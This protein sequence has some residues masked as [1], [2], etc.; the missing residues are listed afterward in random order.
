SEYSTL[1]D[2]PLLVSNEVYYFCTDPSTGQHLVRQQYR[3]SRTGPITVE[4]VGPW[5][6]AKGVVIAAPRAVTYVRRRNFNQFQ[7]RAAMVLMHNESLNH[8]NDYSN[9]HLDGLSRVSYL[10]TKAVGFHLNASIHFYV[11]DTWGYRNTT[12]GLFTGMIGELQADRADIGATPLFF[13]PDRIPV[14]DYIAMIVATKASFLFRAPKLS[15]TDNVFVLPFERYVWYSTISFIV[16][17]ALLMALVLRCEQ[18]YTGRPEP[19][20]AQDSFGLSDT[21]LNSF[22][23][24]CQQGSFIEPKRAASRCLLLICLVLLM[25]LYASYSANIVAMIQSPSTKIQT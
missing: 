5:D 8:L 14:I 20:A 10:I 2:L 24:T 22:G 19:L 21:V 11:V 6:P 16:L 12:A 17:S 13:T 25:F 3:L 18:R 9:K 1:D 23:T 7:L 15:Y 4:T